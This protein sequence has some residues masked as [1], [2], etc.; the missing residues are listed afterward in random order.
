V[1]AAEYAILAVAIVGAVGTAV[2]AFGGKL[3]T[4]FSG[5]L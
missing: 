3:L 1:T 5:I 4:K 2:T